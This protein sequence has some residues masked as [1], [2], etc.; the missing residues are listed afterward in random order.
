MN[1]DPRFAAVCGDARLP[2]QTMG[3]LFP[4]RP[5]VQPPVISSDADEPALCGPAA[6]RRAGTRVSPSARPSKVL[7]RV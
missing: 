2:S 5:R 4:R 7:A 3:R 6:P 1:C